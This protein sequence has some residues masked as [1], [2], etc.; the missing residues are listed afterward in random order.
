MNALESAGVRNVDTPLTP[1]R[2]VEAL[3]QVA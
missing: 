2:I 3:R 1:N